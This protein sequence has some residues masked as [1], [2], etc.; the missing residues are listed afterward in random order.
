[1][2][3]GLAKVLH[4][5]CGQP[6]L[7]FALEACQRPELDRLVV[8]VGHNKEQ[9]IRR[10]ASEKDVIWVEQIEQKGTAHA[11]L[12]CREALSGFSGSV[13]VL[14]GDMPLVRDQMLVELV[15][16]RRQ[17][18]AALTMATAVLENPG[19]YGRIIRSPS[20][21]LEAI[22]EERNCTPQQREI[23]EVNPSYYCFD[24]DEL[25]ST[26]E[27]V[28]PDPVKGEYYVTDVVRLLRSGGRDVSAPIRVLPE[29]AM[30]I[31]SRADLATVGRAMQDRLQQALL[32]EG[33]TIV[34]PDNTWIEV[35]ATLGQDTTVY[36]F[37]F[38]GAGATIGEGCRIGPF[39]CVGGGETVVDG[40][41]VGPHAGIREGVQAS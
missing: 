3:S 37:T 8:V 15:E 23:H 16:A 32:E 21:D 38:I 13:L 35:G 28:E 19:G 22:V 24:A 33:V 39:A 20:G 31:N 27:R 18:G 36:P 40:A 9:V 5:V 7:G 25:F 41:V 34:D 4:E 11:L 14:A 30:G 12:C 6:M 10:F 1:M 2:R 17:S 26:L 29:E